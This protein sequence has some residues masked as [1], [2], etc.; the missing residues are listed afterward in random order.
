MRQKL[1]KSFPKFIKKASS[2][3]S[4]AWTFI[5]IIFLILI[6]MLTGPIMHFSERWQLIITTT[7]TIITFLIVF[8]IQ[9]SQNRDSEYIKVMLE[10]LI[11]INKKASKELLCLDSLTDEDLARLEKKFKQLAKKRI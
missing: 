3:A 8:L 2:I 4:N 6:W 9:N 10:E 11:L 5:F 7:T 1:T